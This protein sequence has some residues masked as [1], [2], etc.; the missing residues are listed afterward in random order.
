MG[1]I[2]IFNLGLV[3]H[4]QDRFSVKAR[5]FYQ[6]ASALL[7]IESG[8]SGLVHSS[9]AS[10]LVR[11]AVLNNLGVWHHDSGEAAAAQ[12]FFRRLANLLTA[13]AARQAQ[14]D[15]FATENAESNNQMGEVNFLYVLLRVISRNQGPPAPNATASVGNVIPDVPRKDLFGPG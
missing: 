10:I 6:I 14:G 9:S 13:T 1:A 8:E 11:A 5:A 3:H 2:N 7:T 4:L 15:V 12:D